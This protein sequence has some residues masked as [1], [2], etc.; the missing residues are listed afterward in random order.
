MITASVAA[1][2]VGCGGHPAAGNWDAETVSSNE[3]LRLEVAFDGTGELYPK[4]SQ[5]SA[6]RCLWQASSAETIGI[7]C[8]HE[9]E[10]MAE[11]EFELIVE[12][13]AQGQRNRALLQSANRVVARFARAEFT[14]KSLGVE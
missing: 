10:N 9:N 1:T 14:K 11:E 13:D 6:L 12:E 3:Y 8:R 5:V 4:E 7:K 2:L